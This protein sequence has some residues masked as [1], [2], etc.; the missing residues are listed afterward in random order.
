MSVVFINLKFISVC[1]NGKLCDVSTSEAYYRVSYATA[2]FTTGS[3]TLGEIFNPTKDCPDIVDQ[4]P[5]AEDGFYWILFPM[6]R[7][8]RLVLDKISNNERSPAIM[9]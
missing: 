1:I 9:N 6:E 8:K 7:S 4:I 2:P 5:E 3:S